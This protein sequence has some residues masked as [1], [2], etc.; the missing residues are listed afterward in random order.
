MRKHPLGKSGSMPQRSGK[1]EIGFYL[2]FEID[3]FSP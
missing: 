2:E 3:Y 1:K